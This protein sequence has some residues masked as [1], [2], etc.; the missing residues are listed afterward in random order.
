MVLFFLNNYYNDIPPLFGDQFDALIKLVK[1]KIQILK[2]FSNQLQEIIKYFEDLLNTSLNILTIESNLGNED[3]YDKL[4]S[5]LEAPGQ[6]SG[7]RMFYGGY[8]IAFGTP[9]PNKINESLDIDKIINLNI[10][11]LA[12]M[13]SRAFV[14]LTQ[15]KGL[16]ATTAFDVLNQKNVMS[17]LLSD[18][19][20]EVLM[21]T[22]NYIC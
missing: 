5:A 6:D 16:K 10:D 4:I 2:N 8:V 14:L 20:K 9:D 13:V 11:I 18:L 1:D 15:L 3:I 22:S 7:R 19:K 21:I 12:T 17:G